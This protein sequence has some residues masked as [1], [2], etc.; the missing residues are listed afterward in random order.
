MKRNLHITSLLLWVLMNKSM[1]LYF[2]I[3]ADLSHGGHFSSA[4]FSETK[5]VNPICFFFNFGISNSSRNSRREMKKI[6][7]WEDSHANVLK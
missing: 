1:E 6:P 3:M 4:L 5:L 2:V 7:L